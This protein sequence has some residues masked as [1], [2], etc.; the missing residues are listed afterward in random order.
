MPLILLEG[1]DL[2]GKSTLAQAL[3]ERWETATGARAIV[4]RAGPPDPKV[5]IRDQ[6]ERPFFEAQHEVRPN[7]LDLLI[8][9]RWYLGEL[10]YGPLLRG[11][12]RLT[13]LMQRHLE[14]VLTSLGA[15][16]VV[17]DVTDEVR[18]KRFAERGD[19]LVS[20]QQATDAARRYRQLRTAGLATT[21]VDG[22]TTSSMRQAGLLLTTARR[23]ATAAAELWPL[24]RGG[25]VGPRRPELLLVGDRRN[26]GDL[27]APF[28]PY[29]EAGCSTYLW[30]ALA[31]FPPVG[32]VNAN[33]SSQVGTLYAALKRPRVVAL[34]RL[35][36]VALQS[37]GVPHGTVPHP[38]WWKRFRHHDQ[39]EYGAAIRRAATTREDLIRA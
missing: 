4:W 13:P 15:L 30:E 36:S 12:S 29:S 38:Q 6:Y 21:W 11:K 35:A 39:S 1:A 25:Y 20:F 24:H 32:L 22:A 18:A 31:Q 17:V 26:G 19:D 27:P 33:E 2:S 5:S 23:E 37:L 9:D 3:S 34:G 14:G 10:V 7:Q 8:C 28:P 16:Q